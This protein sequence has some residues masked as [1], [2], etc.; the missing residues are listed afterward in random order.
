MCERKFKEDLKDKNK[1]LMQ[2]NNSLK[3]VLANKIPCSTLDFYSQ[4]ES[5]E[6]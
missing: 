1:H 6:V 5:L 3:L 2:E 4:A